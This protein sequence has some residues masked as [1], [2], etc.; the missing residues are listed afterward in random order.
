MN[1]FKL[2]WKNI[3]YRPL[4]SGLSILLLAAGISIILVTILTTRQLDDKFKKNVENVD[5]VVGAKE[6]GR[7]HV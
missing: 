7:A 3:K 2:S 4:G 5:F 6:I 1:L